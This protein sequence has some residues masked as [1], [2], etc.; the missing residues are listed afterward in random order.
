MDD[1]SRAIPEY[2]AAPIPLP[3]EIEALRDGKAAA[4]LDRAS[5]SFSG[6]MAPTPREAPLGRSFS[7][8]V[9][10]QVRLFGRPLGFTAS[11]TYGREFSGYDDGT[12]GR[13]ELVG[14]Q[15]IGIDQLTPLRFFGSSAAGSAASSSGY[16]QSGTDEVNWGIVGTLAYKPHPGHSVSTSVIR[17]QSGISQ[18]RTLAGY[19]VDLSGLSTFETRVLGY[20]ERALTSVQGKGEHFLAGMTV[21][22]RVSVARNTQDEPDLRYFSNH[23]TLRDGESGMDTL[24]QSP[25]S[26]Y[27]AP[28]RF[29]RDLTEDSRDLGLD[30]TIPFRSW[31]GLPSRIKAGAAFTD[32]DR[33]FR[34]RRFEYTEGRGFDFGDYGGDV[35]AYFAAVGIIDTTSTGRFVFGNVI[36]DASSV[37]SNYDGTQ[38]VAATYAMVDIAVL[39][40]LRFIGGAR[41]ESTRMETISADSTLPAGLLRND[42]LLPSVN[43]V[44]RLSDG[45][46]VRGAWTRTLARPTFRELAPYATFDFVGDLVFRGNSSLRRTLITNYDLRWEWFSRPGELLAASVFYKEFQDPIER[47]IQTSVGNNSLSVQNVDRAEVHGIELEARSRLDRLHRALGGFQVGGNFTLVRS[48]VRIP[49]E[50]MTI[51]RAADPDARDTRRLDGQSPYLANV[52]VTYETASGRTVVSVLYNVFGDRLIAVTEGAAPD[53]F[54]RPRTALDLVAAQEIRSGVRLKLSVKNLLDSEF[55]TSQQFKGREYVYALYRTGRTVSLG[56]SYSI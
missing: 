41:L 19:W 5:R 53:V 36:R 56:V 11:A 27:P 39:R 49:D 1:G 37:R 32:V 31:T 13:W 24:Y 47:V 12:I 28:T 34:E 3:T 48:E 17:T 23:Y 33:T 44:F 50:E 55:R 52:D 43:L 29:F 40:S 26:L 21:D 6:V 15:L 51:I 38:H 2:L 18:A 42:D 8:A 14:G 22:W 4:V 54:E 20:R 46:N 7:A 9:G 35:D 45:M 25:A 16:D 30:L 10:N